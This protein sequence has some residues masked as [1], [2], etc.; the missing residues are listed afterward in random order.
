LWRTTPRD[1]VNVNDGVRAAGVMVVVVVVCVCHA[2]LPLSIVVVVLVVERA[3]FL[4]KVS[5]SQ[6]C[7]EDQKR[8][9]LKP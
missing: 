8:E 9:D 6:Q 7:G 3:L 4:Y 1:D 5:S 2:P